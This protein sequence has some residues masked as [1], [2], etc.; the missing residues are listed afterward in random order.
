MSISDERH[1]GR[2]TSFSTFLKRI[3]SAELIDDHFLPQVATCQ[4]CYLNIS[5]L[6]RQETSDEDMDYII[7]HATNLSTAVNFHYTK[8]SQQKTQ[9]LVSTKYYQTVTE[10]D[11]EVLIEFI[12]RYKDDYLAFGYD[13]YKDIYDFVEIKLTNKLTKID[14]MQN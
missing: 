5:F 6:G 1:G 13:P 4:V 12:I 8:D 10:T 14:H 7:N 3:T 11:S 2:K 9:K